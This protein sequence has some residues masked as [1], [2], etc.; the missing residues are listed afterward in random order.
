MF[1]LLGITLNCKNPSLVMIFTDCYQLLGCE[2]YFQINFF[3]PFKNNLSFKISFPFVWFIHS[4]YES[5]QKGRRYCHSPGCFPYLTFWEKSCNFSKSK[6]F[7]TFQVCN[8]RTLQ[9]LTLKNFVLKNPSL[10]QYLKFY[11]KR[12]NSQHNCCITSG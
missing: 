11:L 6:T 1:F 8:T 10:P 2:Y 7:F 12:S 9:A 4:V 5:V 3:S